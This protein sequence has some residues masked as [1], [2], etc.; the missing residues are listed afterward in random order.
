MNFYSTLS[1]IQFMGS[2]ANQNPFVDDS[3]VRNNDY[4]PC[5]KIETQ[6]L[7]RIQNGHNVALVGRRRVGKSS[8]A[9]HIVDGLEKKYKLEADFYHITTEADLAHTLVEACQKMM[10][11]IKAS[12]RVLEFIKSIQLQWDINTSTL[13]VGLN[14]RTTPPPQLSSAMDVL[15]QSL[16]QA[17]SQVIILFDEFQQITKLKNSTR[18][19]KYMRGRI[20][21]LHRVSVLY[22]GSVRHEMDH[23]F[24]SPQSPFY[25]QAEVVYFDSIEKEDFFKFVA[26]KIFN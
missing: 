17:R 10:L 20:Q 15:E 23:I 12:K 8:V 11:K 4:C 18:I 24:R 1:K 5:T 9:H 2:K 6:L 13:S 21:K 22:V 7:A 3:I 26:Q 14:Q 25:K 16:T 19:L